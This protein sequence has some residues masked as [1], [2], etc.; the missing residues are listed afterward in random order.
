MFG[1]FHMMIG[2]FLF[3]YGVGNITDMVMAYNRSLQVGAEIGPRDVMSWRYLLIVCI[4]CVYQVCIMCVYQVC[5]K[6]VSSV[7]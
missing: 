2:C 3:A 1:V 6:F 5:I 4:K 7:Y